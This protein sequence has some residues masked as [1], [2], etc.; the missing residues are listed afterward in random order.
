MYKGELLNK[1]KNYISGWIRKVDNNFPTYIKV[2]SNGNVINRILASRRFKDDQID[3]IGNFGFRLSIENLINKGAKQN[4]IIETDDGKFRFPKISI[5]DYKSYTNKKMDLKKRQINKPNIFFIGGKPN[6]GKSTFA[7]ELKDLIMD[8]YILNLDDL[9]KDDMYPENANSQIM[10]YVDSPMF[11]R[12]DFVR[13]F[14]NEYLPKIPLNDFGTIIIEG[15][16]LTF[17]WVRKKFNQVL[18]MYGFPFYIEVENYKVNFKGRKLEKGG[19]ENALEFYNHFKSA[20]LNELTPKTTYQYYE[21][22]GQKAK[23]SKSKE[24]I[25]KAVIPNLKDKTVLDIG[26]N[27]GVMSNTFARSGASKVY[28]IDVRRVSVS[29]ASQYNNTFYHSD[30]VSFHH[31]DVY[32]FFPDKAIDVVY[33]SSVFHYFRER[34]PLFFEHMSNIMSDSGLMIIEIEL[35]EEKQEEAFTYKYKRVV[36]DTPCYF[37]NQKMVDQMIKGKFTI[38]S[39]ALSVNQKGSKLNRYFFHLKKI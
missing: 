8:V 14:V 26:C 16:L 27:A 24:K 10:G 35:F 9:F 6:S 36:D 34:Q 7:T 13:L 31:I 11:N 3:Q 38:Q 37:P 20:R 15:W 33:A 30:N 23:N 25:E 5:S 18:N 19:R 21:D 1:N 22:L 2:I 4:I 29:V 32:D 39:K 12:E 28:G 17:E